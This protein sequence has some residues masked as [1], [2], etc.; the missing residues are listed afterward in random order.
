MMCKHSFY[1]II[2]VKRPLDFIPNGLFIGCIN[3]TLW[4]FRRQC[5][6]L[7]ECAEATC[8]YSKL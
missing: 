6:Y 2:N 4:L 5:K 8:A 3:N 7:F 1:D